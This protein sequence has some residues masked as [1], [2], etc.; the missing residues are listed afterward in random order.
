MP[1]PAEPHFQ[2]DASG[3]A[4][5]QKGVTLLDGRNQERANDEKLSKAMSRSLLQEWQTWLA[6]C[7]G[8]L[9]FF[10]AQLAAGHWIVGL[11]IFNTVVVFIW[12]I[13]SANAKRTRAM[14]EWIEHQR[15]LEQKAGGSGGD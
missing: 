5:F 1:L 8:I 14:L 12:A 7:I 11:S 10:Q 2:D 13:D 4:W 6:F 15:K 3:E 9:A